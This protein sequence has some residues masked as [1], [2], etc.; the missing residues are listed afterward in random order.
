[1]SDYMK[2]IAAY[3]T[4]TVPTRGNM[5]CV[6]QGLQSASRKRPGV[7]YVI[8][9]G[10]TLPLGCQPESKYTERK[11][12][13]RPFKM[14]K[15]PSHVVWHGD[16]DALKCFFF[17]FLS[18]ARLPYQEKKRHFGSGGSCQAT[19]RLIAVLLKNKQKQG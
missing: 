4:I 7:P 14:A 8:S 6:F 18:E 13:V 19:E 16:V 12:F 11:L 5:K 3:H 9:C 2:F 15:R 1:M 10:S 17:N